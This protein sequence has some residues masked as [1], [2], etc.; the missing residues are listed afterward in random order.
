MTFF[1]EWKNE[2]ESGMRAPEN[3]EELYRIPA[4]LGDRECGERYVLICFSVNLGFTGL[5]LSI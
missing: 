4:G 5:D 2:L 3:S 1:L